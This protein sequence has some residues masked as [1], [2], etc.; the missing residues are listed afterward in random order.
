MT[1]KILKLLSA[2]GGGHQSG[3]AA[4]P[5]VSGGAGLPHPAAEAGSD[6]GGL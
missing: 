5:P 1:E 2:M 3:G 4:H 6:G